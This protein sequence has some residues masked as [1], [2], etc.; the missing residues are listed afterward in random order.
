MAESD[1]EEAK[2]K[3]GSLIGKVGRKQTR[4]ERWELNDKNDY[5]LK[6]YCEKNGRISELVAMENKKQVI[7]LFIQ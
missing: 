7:F 1:R 6:I 4:N 2:W 3:P 5:R